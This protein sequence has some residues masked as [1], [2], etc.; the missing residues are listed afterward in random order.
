MDPVMHIYRVGQP[1][2]TQPT[3]AK[4]ESYSQFV[5]IIG[6]GCEHAEHVAVLFN[7]KRAHMFVD[8][9][10]HHEGLPRNDAATAI[11]RAN[12]LAQHP[13]CD[14]ETLPWIAGDAV[15]LEGVTIA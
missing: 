3:A 2:E 5:P 4:V 15:V 13:D 12:W 8:E 7:G 1:V 14:P 9:M 10:G 6:G 11:Y